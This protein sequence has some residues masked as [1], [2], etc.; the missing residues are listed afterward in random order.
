M[1]YHTKPI[2]KGTL[3][4]FSKIQEEFEELVDAR[5][6]D[7]IIL[8]LCEAA[9]LIGAI[10]AYFVNYHAITLKDLIQMKNSTKSAFESGE[11]K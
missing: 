8:Q 11:R 9:D 5:G 7:N 10:E 6:Q 3:G 1:G 4:E 2:T